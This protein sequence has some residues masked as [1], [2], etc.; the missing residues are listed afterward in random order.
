MDH[1]LTNKKEY[2]E[3]AIYGICSMNPASFFMQEIILIYLETLAFYLLE[4]KE[5]G[6]HNNNIMKDVLDAFSGPSTNVE[7]N[8]ANLNNL[9]SRLYDDLGEAQKL[10]KVI[11]AE[12]N[13]VPKY[14]KTSIKLAN[15]FNLTSVIKQGQKIVNKR[16]QFLNEQQKNMV[17]VLHQILKSICLYIIE[18]QELNVNTED[19]YKQL[20][21]ALSKMNL[22]TVIE[23]KLEELIEKAVKLDN[24][25]MHKT[26]DGRKAEF[27]EITPT[28]VSLS[29]RPGK[30]ILVAGANMK[31]LELILKATQDKGIDIYTHGQMIVGHTFPK[32][33]SYPNLVGHYGK[34]VEYCMSDFSSFPG[35]IYLSKLSLYN[36][37]HL[38]HGRIFTSDKLAQQGVTTL[39]E[40]DFEPLI[41]SAHLAEGFTETE[42]KENVHIGF[43]EENFFQKINELAD[44]IESKE[45]KHLIAIGVSNNT[46]T[47]KKY[48]ETI[49]NQMEED[50]FVISASY[51]NNSENI[52]PV[53]ID[54]VFPFAYKTIEILAQRNLFTDLNTTSFYTRCEPHTIPNLFMM[55]YVGVKN[56]YFD[57]CTSNVLNPALIDAIRE[58]LN[59]RFNTNP[60]DDLKEILGKKE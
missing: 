49:L 12:K 39:N 21:A 3:C 5:H 40:N 36:I 9:I 16:N 54:Y 59:I 46:E 32:I 58:P 24:E 11:C 34:G 25:L 14:L 2:D 41:R 52:L 26:F 23:E 10:Y 15:T 30:A 29:T 38:Y 51:T 35:S 44:K 60:E 6:L 22:D 31:E 42:T 8:Q 28:E 45:I 20:L 19:A 55:K 17:S 18:L 50:C 33:K 7:Y 48:F 13:I 1:N 56:I 53:N 57:K 47:Q 27:G 37:G 43:H 4:L